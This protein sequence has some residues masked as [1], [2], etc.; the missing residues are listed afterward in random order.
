MKSQNDFANCDVVVIDPLSPLPRAHKLRVAPYIRVSSS[1]EDQLHSYAAQMTY[2]TG[3]F[4]KH[5]DWTMVDIY[6]DEGI[7]GTSME[8]RDDLLR[9]MRDCRR[10]LVDRVITKSVARFA[11][12]LPELLRSVRE[13]MGLGVSIHFEAE[14]IDTA[15]MKDEQ[16]LTMYAF[17]AQQESKSISKNQRMSVQR[18]MQMGTIVPWNASYG[19]CLTGT[20]EQCVDDVPAKVLNQMFQL[21]YSGHGYQSIYKMLLNAGVR[22]KSGKELAISTIRFILQNVR[23]KG[24]SIYGKQY[25]TDTLP[26]RQVTNHGEA[27]LY[28]I[29]GT[30]P[31]I[32]STDV[33]D[34]VQS[35]RQRKAQR[36]FHPS[37][38]IN[39]PLSL[40]IKCFSCGSTFKRKVVRG[41][42]YWVCRRHNLDR[43]FCTQGAVP[44]DSFY[45]AFCSLYN[46]LRINEQYILTPML[47][48]L[49]QLNELRLWDDPQ[50]SE[51][52]SSLA[53]LV[54]Q[55]RVL[56]DL[57]VKG[58][59]DPVLFLSKSNDLARRIQAI[60]EA[61]RRLYEVDDETDPS[62]KTEELIEALH[63]G[64]DYLDSFDDAL[65][66]DMVD[67]ITV[68]GKTMQF[69]LINGLVLTE[70]GAS[71]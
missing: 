58:Y 7:T 45:A 20:P 52:N 15:T 62:E 48:Q 43:S 57:K 31:A 39:Y 61:K 38:G 67:H 64:P 56:Y 28:Y 65:F 32:I 68:S 40:K 17:C 55:N 70:Q 71:L 34:G 3:L 12:N 41:T 25:K 18:R 51:L 42:V 6:A 8:K 50:L 46:R 2:Y 10:G 49:Q 47:H 22:T 37:S 60:R 21:Y 29:K 63:R 36:Y 4:N 27:P 30:Q 35:F 53:D 69:H 66:T 44:E 26:R 5:D 9:L 1:S 14:N 59:V 16:A 24:D 19:Y 13:L 23:Y 11:R 54:E 33:F